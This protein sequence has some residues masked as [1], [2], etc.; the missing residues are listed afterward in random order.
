MFDTQLF[1]SEIEKR[2]ALYNARHK[3]YSDRELKYK[4]WDEIAV[5]MYNN[6]ASLS[7]QEC[8]KKGKGPLILYYV[9]IRLQTVSIMWDLFDGR[10]VIVPNIIFISCFI[11]SK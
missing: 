11:I 4:L 1:I 7:G 9:D 10:N 8:R 6:W 2:P 5:V 3:E